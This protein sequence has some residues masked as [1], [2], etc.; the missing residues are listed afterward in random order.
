MKAIRYERYGAPQDI[1]ELRD[2]PE[3]EPADEQVLLRVRAS[4]ANPVEWY[5]VT[6][7]V[8]GR[9]Q[10]G[11]RRPKT[12]T[13][14]ADVAGVVERVGK[15]VAELRPGDEVF[16][17]CGGAWAEYAVARE[18]RLA[19]KPENVSFEEAASVPIAGLTALQA[20]RNHGNVQPGQHVLVNGG[21]GGVGTFAVQLVKVFGAEVTAVCSTRNVEAAQELGADHV[22][23][24]T[25]EDFTRSGARYDL[26]IDIA[27]SRS[28]GELRRVVKRD[29]TVVVVGAPRGNRIVGPLAHIIGMK[30]TSFGRS[31]NVVF[32]VTKIEK[33]DLELMSDL[34][35]D[36][37]VKPVVERRYEL[38]RASDALAY[39]G[40]GHARGKVVITA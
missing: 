10:G 26:A 7:L 6:G 25:R 23:D 35:A 15:D 38:A 22:L 3:P 11:V 21:S 33:A 37:K 29:G 27:G 18:A 30:V 20:L 34:L 31:P 9:F 36:G 39:L 40:E 5:T 17:T 14:G 2:V 28:Y 4:S 12:S 19:R 13:V 32:F 16:G 8:L 1:F 24:Y